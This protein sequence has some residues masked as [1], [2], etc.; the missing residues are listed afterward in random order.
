M[1]PLFSPSQNRDRI[2][3]PERGMPPERRDLDYKLDA[4]VGKTAPNPINRSRDH[5]LTHSR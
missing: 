2:P 4:T 3:L 5:E 1:T